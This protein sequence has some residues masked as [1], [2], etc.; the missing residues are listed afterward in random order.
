VV[1]FVMGAVFGL[2]IALN[3]FVLLAFAGHRPE[4]HDSLPVALFAV[5]FVGWLVIPL[6]G[7]GV[8]ETLD[9]T[10]LALLPLSTRQ[11]TAGLLVASV[12]GIAP[13]ATLIALSGAVAGYGTFG[14]GTV[15]IVAAIVLELMLCLVG[16]RALT[17][18]LSRI[19]RSRRARD[20]WAAFASVIGLVVF[21]LGQLPRLMH[22][23]PG[24]EAVSRVEAVLRWL[25]PG[26]LGR[27]V[28]E[29]GRGRIAVPALELVPAAVLIVLLFRWWSTGMDRLMT[30]VER[31]AVVR[32]GSARPATV[33]ELF[34]RLGRV[35]PRDRR[36][37]V[38]AKDLRYFKR[39]PILRVQ[40]LMA[41]IY[42]LGAAVFLVFLALRDRQAPLVL[43]TALIAWWLAMPAMTMFG[44]D[45]SAYWMNVAA[46]GDPTDD[47]AG[48]NAAIFLTVMPVFAVASL[49]VAVVSGGW[50]YLPVGICLAAAVVASRL[51]VGSVVSV[52][53]AR[54]VAESRTNMWAARTGQGCGTALVMLGALLLDQLL[55]LP[56]AGLVLVGLIVWKPL[57]IV[58]VPAALAYGALL[59]RTGFR[60]AARWIRANQPELL[61]SLSPRQA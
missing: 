44:F 20:M 26:M 19:L 10:R 1:S 39:D 29:A 12:V 16:A 28:A 5:L 47:L 33:D 30:T 24:E 54:P 11:L 45:R 27:A 23:A 9:P 40:R 17:T 31:P 2:W 3:G 22:R 58:A 51:A 42:S 50:I 35:L 14:F 53:L 32:Q 41:L 4:L 6:V 13:A 52:R 34:G 25:P 56:L 49:V 46:G 7:M 61:E 15:L 8:D 43:G 60:M 55:L 36:G 18:A 57:L 37:A 21:F 38:A 59:Y 48:K